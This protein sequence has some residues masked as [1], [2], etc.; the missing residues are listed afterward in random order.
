MPAGGHL[1]H[2]HAALE[3]RPYFVFGDLLANAS[4]GAAV[5][6]ICAA[7][8]GP[9]W[10]MVLAMFAGMALGMALSL[11]PALGFGALFG[12]MEVMV[13]VMTTGMV[14]GMVVSMA[15]A[16]GEV[17]LAR[18]AQLG[19]TSGVGVMVATYAAN[20]VIRRRAPRWTE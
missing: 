6:L 11:P 7:C 5:G 10:N 13:P 9:A 19:L 8:F 3:T 2:A 12:A 18:G 16:M 20:A 14:A 17:S 4:V 1:T 15:G